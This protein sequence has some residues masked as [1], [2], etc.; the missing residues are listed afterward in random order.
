[1]KPS[2]SSRFN[3]SLSTLFPWLSFLVLCVAAWLRIWQVHVLPPAPY[4]EEVALGFDAYSVLQTGKD[5]HGADYPLVAFESFGDW[6]PSGYFYAVIPSIA[7]FGLN[8]FAIR[9]PS[10]LAGI[11][12]VWL[13]P[14]FVSAMLAKKLTPVMTLGARL[15]A[16]VSPWLLVFSRSAWEVNLALCMMV[17][18]C[19]LWYQALKKHRKPVFWWLGIAAVFALAGS[20]YTYHAMRIIAP[21]WTLLFT[22]QSLSLLTWHKSWLMLL[23]KM[24]P[25][26]LLGML[27]ITPILLQLQSPV[28]TQRFQETSIFADS[29]PVVL[30]NQ[31]RAEHG[32]TLLARV[33][34][35]R[36]WFITARVVTNVFDHLNLDF[37]FVHGDPNA[38]HRGPMY[39]QLLY[40][41]AILIAIGIVALLFRRSKQFWLLG[42]LWLAAVLPAALTTATPHA[43]RTLP[44]VLIWL[45]LAI[46]GAG[47][48]VGWW[49]KKLPLQWLTNLGI[50]TLLLLYGLFAGV[51]WRSY[52]VLTP[53]LLAQDWQYGYEA[54][55]QSVKALQ[56]TYPDAVTTVSREIGRPAMYWWFYNKTK[57]QDVQLADALALK[58]QGEFLSFESLRFSSILADFKPG[59]IVALTPTQWQTIKKDHPTWQLDVQS[60]IIMPNRQPVWLVGLLV[61]SEL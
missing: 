30:S 23:T 54:M 1:M 24:M 58:D 49:Q 8:L 21:L 31:L 34:Y 55:I 22:I 59:Q 46:E 37:L 19:L 9:L 57:P 40:P 16:A 6:K 25:L 17:A 39:G 13:F 33:L 45:T 50:A 36:Y 29:Q 56:K 42:A 5:H 48:L 60:T 43:L 3:F 11:G 12:L 38:R 7:A 10:V 2:A 27:L 52:V 32:D 15:I 61:E 41:D 44:T 51:W 18:G 14:Q 28:I 26:A 4:W 35:H 20:M 47:V 53:Q